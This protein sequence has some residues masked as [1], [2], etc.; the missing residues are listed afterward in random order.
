ME[1]LEHIEAMIKILVRQKMSNKAEKL[2][3]EVMIKGRLNTKQVMNYLGI[4]RPHSL[5]LM[6]KLGKQIGFKFK[7]G[8][9]R[10]RRSSII[11]YDESQII[12]DQ[13]K[14]IDKILDIKG[15]VNFRELMNEFGMGVN[16][17]RLIVGDYVNVHKECEIEDENKLARKKKTVN[18]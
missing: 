11:V 3:N 5:T 17:I 9:P 4:S 16:D 7:N 15:I 12:K 2:M 13:H 8:D 18:K 6:E 10:T 14:R 1:E